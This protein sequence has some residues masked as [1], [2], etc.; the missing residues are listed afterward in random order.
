MIFEKKKAREEL[1]AFAERNLK[2]KY[3]YFTYDGTGLT[4]KFKRTPS[5]MSYAG[6]ITMD[7]ATGKCFYRLSFMINGRLPEELVHQ[8]EK[9][10][11]EGPQ[12]KFSIT[13]RAAVRNSLRRN[14]VNTQIIK[15]PESDYIS[16][17]EGL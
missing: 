9:K 3:H 4:V 11:T 16:C 12:E 10:W 5:H 8:L 14:V 15:T 1:E 7:P 17:T 2:N 13:Q 6:N